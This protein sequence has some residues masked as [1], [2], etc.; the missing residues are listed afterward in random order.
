MARYKA[1]GGWGFFGVVLVFGLILALLGITIGGGASARI[2]F[3]EVNISLGAS[4]GEKEV[5]QQALPNYLRDKVADNKNFF[6][7]SGTLTIWI[8]EGMGVIVLGNQP[9]APVIDLNINY[10]R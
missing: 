3:T 6:N 4:L 5:V 7:Q 2:P 1:G 10:L 9:N 8:A